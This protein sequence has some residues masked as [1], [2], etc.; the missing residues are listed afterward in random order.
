MNRGKKSQ[1]IEDGNEVDM[2]EK[3]IF[4][5]AREGVVWATQ[6]RV[7]VNFRHAPRGRVDPDLR[8]P[9]TNFL[10]SRN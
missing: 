9:T 7:D 10:L 1:L 2:A 3:G 8:N 6:K 5:K 4:M